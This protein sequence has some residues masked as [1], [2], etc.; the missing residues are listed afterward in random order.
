MHV[1]VTSLA[2]FLSLG[3]GLQLDMATAV[4][5]HP[6]CPSQDVQQRIT[7][8]DVSSVY[9]NQTWISLYLHLCTGRTEMLV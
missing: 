9:V 7:R 8:Q 2:V 1:S 5:F 4:P 3:S 6:G